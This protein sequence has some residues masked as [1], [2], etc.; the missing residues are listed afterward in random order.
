MGPANGHQFIPD[1]FREWN[2]Y[3][4]VGMHMADLASRQAILRSAEAMRVPTHSWPVL[5]TAMEFFAGV[6]NW[7]QTPIFADRILGPKV[8]CPIHRMFHPELKMPST[9]G[10]T[11]G[12]EDSAFRYVEYPDKEAAPMPKAKQLS[13]PARTAL[14]R[15]PMSQG[16]ATASCTR[17]FLPRARSLPQS[18]VFSTLP[19]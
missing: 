14:G 3:E 10:L 9:D 1:R 7:H 11:V 13:V 12:I 18:C 16:S 2:V 19:L 15:W 8:T 6:P 17:E 4:A 5:Y